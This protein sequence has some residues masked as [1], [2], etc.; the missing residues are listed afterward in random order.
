MKY[1]TASAD[2]IDAV[3]ALHEKYHIDSI[4]QEDKKDG[5]VTT[6]F[7]PGLLLELINKEKGLF[8]AKDRG[9]VAAYAMSASWDFCS[10]WPMFRYMISCL[11]ELNYM[12]QIVSVENSYQYGP[13]CVDKKY[14]GSGVFEKLFDFARMEMNKKYP[15]LITFVNKI[16]PRSV[17]VHV[18]KLGLDLLKEFRF[19]NNNYLELAYDASKP[20]LIKEKKSGNRQ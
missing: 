1:I 14:R 20:V 10:R 4:E 18:D 17:K 6:Q 12:G 9:Q 8:I 15:I 13:V 16:N 5:F 2:D 7:T 19:N 11:H 3:L